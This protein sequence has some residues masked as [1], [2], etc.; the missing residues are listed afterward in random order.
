MQVVS[1]IA[2]ALLAVCLAGCGTKVP[3]QTDHTAPAEQ[4]AVTEPEQAWDET[5]AYERLGT[6]LPDGLIQLLTAAFQNGT[7]AEVLSSMAADSVLSEQELAAIADETVQKYAAYAAEHYSLFLSADADNDGVRDILACIADGGSMGN[8]SLILL[9]GN[10]DGSYEVSERFSSLT[11]ELGFIS[12]E[13][14][15]YLLQTLFDYNKKVATGVR[16]TR[17]CSGVRHDALDIQKTCGAYQLTGSRVDAGY[18]SVAEACKRYTEEY[19][20]FSKP[21]AVAG[22][23][24]RLE[25]ERAVVEAYNRAHAANAQAWYAADIDNDGVEEHYTKR[26]FLSSTIGTRMQ[27]EDFLYTAAA[28]ERAENIIPYYNIPYAGVPLMVWVER[29]GTKQVLCT[30]CYDGLDRYHL[31][32]DVIQDTNVTRVLELDYAADVSVT[33][34]SVILREYG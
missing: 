27:L 34:D 19:T 26:V 1:A 22:T 12:Y 8:N 21:S 11:T 25:T 9:R 30:L 6:E 13:G 10:A 31:Y 16:V 29:A 32:G 20:M 4:P 33:C 23:G 17:F 24:E 28:P 18:A 2:A 5:Q 15:R 14:R 7:E 3:A